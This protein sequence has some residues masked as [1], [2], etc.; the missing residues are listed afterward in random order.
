MATHITDDVASTCDRVVV[1][2][3]GSVL[4]SGAVIVANLVADILYGYL[5]PRVRR[6]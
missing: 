6:A 4:F 3:N 1:I 5:D 2:D